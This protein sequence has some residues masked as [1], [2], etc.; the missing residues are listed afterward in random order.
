MSESDNK[1]QL[2]KAIHALQ[3]AAEDYGL[4]TLLVTSKEVEIRI[5]R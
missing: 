2:N 1:F 3:K 5:V 4:M